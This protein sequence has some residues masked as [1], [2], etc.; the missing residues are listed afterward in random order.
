MPIETLFRAAYGLNILILLPV[1]YSL[2]LN[3]HSGGLRAFERK[4]HDSPPLRLLI[5]SLWFAILTCSICGLF[6]PLLFWPILFLQVIYKSMYLATFLIP[7]FIQKGIRS[8]PLGITISFAFIVF[9]YT[10]LLIR[11]ILIP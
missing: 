1:C 9:A 8:L 5:A 6:F 4:V 11:F 2:F 7:Q 10:A 3:D